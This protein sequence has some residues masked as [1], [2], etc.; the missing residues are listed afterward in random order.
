MPFVF[1]ASHLLRLCEIN[2]FPVP[3]DGIVIFGFRGCLPL[4][5]DSHDFQTEHKLLLTQTNYINPHCTLGQWLPGEGQIAFFPGSTVPHIKYIRISKERN[6]LGANQL[7][8]GYYKDY[9]KG[10]H[11]I[12]KPT[13]H[14][15]FRQTEAHP[16]RRTAD[17][18]DFDNDDRVE[19]ENPYDNIHAAWCMGINHDHYASAGCQVVVGYPQCEKLGN[20]PDQGPWKIFKENAYTL[21]QT[22]FPYLLLT[23]R[24]AQKV[25]L[26]S[27]KQ[28]PA[29]LR[30]G[31]QGD[32]VSK[33]QTALKEL[34]YYEGN[35]DQDF[36][37]KTIR[38]V[39]EFQTIEFGENADDGIVGPITASGLGL[40]WHGI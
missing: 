1:T 8:T 20:K 12:G 17:D 24:D 40:D 2:S 25:V 22:H 30:F 11:R 5:D 3:D 27:D 10:R 13:E 14:E 28:M 19:F 35:V 9:R 23:G 18:F 34:N 15:A 36:G 33:L 21:P 31:S 16:I 39:L 37:K 29:R 26:S 7:M 38:A 4:D 32:L 6:G